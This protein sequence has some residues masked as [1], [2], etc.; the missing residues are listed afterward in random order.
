MASTIQ[1]T[2]CSGMG[3]IKKRRHRG[4]TSALKVVVPKPSVTLAI[5]QTTS[6]EIANASRRSTLEPGI[7]HLAY[8][9]TVNA[10]AS[11]QAGSIQLSVR[12]TRESSGSGFRSMCFEPV[13]IRAML[14]GTIKRIWVYASFDSARLSVSRSGFHQ[15]MSDTRVRAANRTVEAR[16]EL[17][18]IED[19]QSVPGV[20]LQTRKGALDGEGCPVTLDAA[21]VSERPA[22][23][24]REIALDLLDL[25]RGVRI[26]IGM[27]GDGEICQGKRQAIADGL[28]ESF[29]AGPTGVEGGEAKMI[30]QGAKCGALARRKI[31]LG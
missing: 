9:P 20:S 26:G 8:P 18:F 29:L 3:T 17:C 28:Q 27:S 30:G 19:S 25:R 23:A 2:P 21:E 1:L 7:P 4:N 24:G 14:R 10:R 22:R 16:G 11:A 31:A 15:K 6:A 13:K 5:Q 12:S